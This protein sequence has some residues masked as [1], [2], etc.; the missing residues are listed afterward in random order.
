MRPGRSRVVLAAGAA[1][2]SMTMSSCS[3]Q[4]EAGTP[5][6]VPPAAPPSLVSPSSV[7]PSSVANAERPAMLPLAGVMPCELVTDAM[8]R[9]FAI[10]RPDQPSAPDPD[11]P[12]CVFIS[13]T[14]GGYVVSTV[15]NNGI[16]ALGRPVNATVGGFPAVDIRNPGDKIGHLSVDVADGQRLDIEVQRLG[17]DQA[18]EE[19]YRDTAEFAEG[20]VAALRQRL[21]R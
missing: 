19:I 18:D 8:R 2:F 21:G 9:R 15:R 7:P 20:V 1:V 6:A 5:T 11:A 17:S 13:T 16:E 14:T 10:D 4:H 12:V 3:A